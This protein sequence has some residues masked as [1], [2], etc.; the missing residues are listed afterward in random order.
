MSAKIPAGRELIY[1]GEL[2]V[3]RGSAQPGKLTIHRADNW[4]LWRIIDA[5]EAQ[6]VEAVA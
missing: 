6:A 4:R 5:N 1:R 3:S 2:Y